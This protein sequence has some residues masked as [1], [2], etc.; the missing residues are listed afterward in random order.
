MEEESIQMTMSPVSYVQDVHIIIWVS[1]MANARHCLV[2]DANQASVL[3][4]VSR[5]KM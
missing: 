4:V 3:I 2:Y 1:T 5:S